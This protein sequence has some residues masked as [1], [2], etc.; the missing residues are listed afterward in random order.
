LRLTEELQRYR[1]QHG[2]G[3]SC[4]SA[5][6]PHDH[7]YRILAHTGGIVVVRG[8]GITAS[9]VIER[10]LEVSDRDGPQVKVVHVA[11]GRTSRGGREAPQ[12]WEHQPYNFPKAALG[13]QIASR[14][15]N[16]DDDAVRSAAIRNLAG[17]TTPRRRAWITQLDRA[18]AA[19]TFRTIVGVISQLQPAADGGVRVTVADRDDPRLTTMFDAKFLIDCTG[20]AAPVAADPLLSSLVRSG[21]ATTNGLDRLHVDSHFEIPQAREPQG[22]IFATGALTM[23]SRIGPVDSFWGLQAA[24]IRVCD[25]LADLGF[26]DH[27]GIRR[28]VGGWWRWMRGRPP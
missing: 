25:R 2:D 22:A 9:R 15:A 27:I 16:L 6:E 5:Y 18:R 21:L 23:G 11:R 26:C 14:L 4:V 1:S 13:G 24:A 12:I 28:S 8:V 10:L 17:T 20:L 3:F 7:I 19:G